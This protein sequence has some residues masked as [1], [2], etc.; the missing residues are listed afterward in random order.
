MLAGLTSPLRF[1]LSALLSHYGVRLNV[2]GHREL[3]PMHVQVAIDKAEG[4][5][6]QNNRYVP[7]TLAFYSEHTPTEQY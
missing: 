3:L 5:T 7:S 2:L 6:R 1:L 4:M